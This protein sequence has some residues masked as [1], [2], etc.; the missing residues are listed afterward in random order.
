MLPNFHESK[1]LAIMA[2]PARTARHEALGGIKFT[3]SQRYFALRDHA[4]R[5]FSRRPEFTC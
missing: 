5:S 2:P 3:L 4:V 1:I